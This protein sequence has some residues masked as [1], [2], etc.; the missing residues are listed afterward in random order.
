MDR[1]HFCQSAIGVA[2]AASLPASQALATY[3]Q[4]LTTVSG[5]VDAISANGGDTILS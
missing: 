2:V 3:L 5:D 1:R 4:L